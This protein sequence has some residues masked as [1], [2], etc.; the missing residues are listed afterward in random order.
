MFGHVGK[1]WRDDYLNAGPGALKLTAPQ[2]GPDRIV[3]GGRR[4]TIGPVHEGPGFSAIEFV[5]DE[6]CH[7]PARDHRV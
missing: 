3:R 1:V 7:A 5:R 4:T 6:S 2:E